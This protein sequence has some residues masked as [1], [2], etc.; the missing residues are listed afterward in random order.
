MGTLEIVGGVLLLIASVLII[1]IV[2]FQDSKDPGLSSAIQ[3]GSADSYFGK[4]SSRTKEARMGRITKVCAIIFFVVTILVN[5]FIMI[6]SD[7]AS[8]NN[9]SNNGGNTQVVSNETPDTTKE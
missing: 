4:N 2:L 7:K 8:A 5:V 3:G 6:S 1:L 9:N